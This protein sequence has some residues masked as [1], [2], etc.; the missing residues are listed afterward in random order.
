MPKLFGRTY[1][2]REVLD[3]VGDVS[4]VANARKAAST[5][6]IER[7]SDL[8]E[9]FNVN[10]HCVGGLFAYLLCISFGSG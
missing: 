9:V 5:E 3:L 6:G 2:K 7:G 4:Q 1:S 8:I 10:L